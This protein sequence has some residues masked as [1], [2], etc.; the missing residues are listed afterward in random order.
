MSLNFPIVLPQS[1]GAPSR[2]FFFGVITQISTHTLQELRNVGL[3]RPHWVLALTGLA[4]CRTDYAVAR[5][6]R[7][8]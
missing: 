1:P 8:T 5:H 3:D 7:L 2:G 6:Q 4:R